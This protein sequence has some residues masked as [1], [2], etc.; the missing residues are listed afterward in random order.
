MIFI[1]YKIAHLSF[2]ELFKHN[3]M[4]YGFS[5]LF[6]P[7]HCLTINLGLSLKKTA[8]CLGFI[9]SL[10][11]PY[12]RK[13]VTLWGHQ[14]QLAAINSPYNHSKQLSLGVIAFKQ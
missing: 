13:M 10:Y 12:K 3:F 2:L 4:K 5:G 7:S 6:Y 9:I 8:L 1:T 11:T 14:Q